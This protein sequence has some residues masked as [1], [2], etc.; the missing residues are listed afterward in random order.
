MVVDESHI[1]HLERLAALELDDAERRALAGHLA[2]I[3]EWVAQLDTLDTTGAEPWAHVAD[4]PA[5]RRPDEPRPCLTVAEALAASPAT[6]PECFVVPP[7]LGG[8]SDGRGVAGDPAAAP[9]DGA[10]AAAAD[11][12]PPE[13]PHG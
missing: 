2:R 7:V 9:A 1:R 8:A 4:R 10:S 13:P 11:P 6:D 5:P 12:P 3:V